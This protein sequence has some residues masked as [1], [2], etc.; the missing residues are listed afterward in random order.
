MRFNRF[1]IAFHCTSRNCVEQTLLQ[2]TKPMSKKDGRVCER[3]TGRGR[4]RGERERQEAS[5]TFKIMREEEGRDGSL[6]L[7]LKLVK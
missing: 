4:G 5:V 2:T 3:E 1:S 7:T 6:V